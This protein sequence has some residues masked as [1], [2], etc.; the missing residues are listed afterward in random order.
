MPAGSAT[1]TLFWSAESL[2]ICFNGRTALRDRT[3]LPFAESVVS[4]VEIKAS[5]AFVLRRQA[6]NTWL[7]VEPFTAAPTLNRCGSCLPASR[8]SKSSTSRKMWWT[9]FSVYGL[10][11][12]GP[13]VCLENGCH[14]CA[15]H[16]QPRAHAS[17]FGT[18]RMDKIFARR[19]RE[20]G[21]HRQFRV[22]SQLP[23]SAFEMR[24]RRI[25]SFDETNVVS[26]TSLSGAR[27]TGS[28][29]I[30]SACGRRILFSTRTWMR[31]CI[32]WANFA[33]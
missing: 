3:L 27:P 23:Q 7:V 24:D 16:D 28:K 8:D 9:I 11:R 4:R 20:R 33:R 31:S 25:W 19:G 32:A 5:Q 6:T 21:L 18:N 1:A 12:T 13:Q 29:E 22:V 14:Q 2:P 10:T 17:E 15:G 30:P 26:I